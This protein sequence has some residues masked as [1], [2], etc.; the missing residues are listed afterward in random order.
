M[1]FFEGL[2]KLKADIIF[3]GGG[4]K[5]IGFVGAVCALE[6]NGYKWGKVAGS[7][8]GAIIAS[9]IAAGYNGKDLKNIMMNIDYTKFIG[10]GRYL[11]IPFRILNII[12]RK[13][14]YSGDYIENFVEEL[15]E[16]KHK[17]KF[18]DVSLNGE[19]N[20][21]IIA[22]DVTQKKL[23]IL[24][25]DIKD[26]G[27]DPMEFKISTAVRMSVGIPFYFRPVYIKYN[28]VNNYIVDGGILSNFPVW[29]FD[30]EGVPRWPT[31]GLKFEK[32]EKGYSNRDDNFISYVL[33]LA[34]CIIETYD[35]KYISDKDMIRTISIPTLNVKTT[36]FN[37]SKEKSMKLFE[38]GYKTAEEFF[39]RWN[40]RK[41][42]DKHRK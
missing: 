3:E 41:Y 26:Y 5:A 23:L 34:E 35:E 16:T 15:L 39:T 42:V 28:G 22:A 14:L 33:D 4:V 18:K 19:S 31:F 30:V 29:I 7:S 9:L 32:S 36:D 1:H 12:L 6:Q 20:L 25:D 21:K 11:S 37:I 10:K 24:P 13:G 40:F 17:T 38:A 27:I 8:A 2:F